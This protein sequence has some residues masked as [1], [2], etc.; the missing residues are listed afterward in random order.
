MDQTNNISVSQKGTEK[1]GARDAFFY[2]TSFFLLYLS[3]PAIGNIF[4]QLI[5]RFF[6]DIASSYYSRATSFAEGSVRWAIAT[7]IISAPIYFVLNSMI[8]KRLSNG[9]MN[10]K[11]GIRKWLT[12]LSLFVAAATGIIDVIVTLNAFLAGEI[13]TR[14][15]LK[16]LVVLILA[17]FVFVY[18]LWDIRFDSS[19]KSN[20]RS[21]FAV[22][23]VVVTIAAVVC[24]FLITSGPGSARKKRIDENR[25]Q[26]LRNLFNAVNNYAYT[27]NKL[28]ANLQEINSNNY[29][30][31]EDL[32][33]PETGKPYEYRP[34]GV[35]TYELCAT[36]TTSNKNTSY[37]VQDWQHDI[38][39]TCFKQKAEIKKK[40]VLEIL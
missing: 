12:Y 24:G 6:P 20:T 2:L 32:V 10:P 38:G 22:I 31:T 18:Y 27:E 39:R 21:I 26:S 3:V 15:A 14:F 34:T 40:S 1:Q 36:F 8:N 29:R 28:P 19:Q 30:T 16:A 37:G 7:L 4:F 33:D 25:L 9:S 11:S 13:G 17:A 35:D 5:N 23:A